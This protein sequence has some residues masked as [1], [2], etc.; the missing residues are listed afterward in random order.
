M[1]K[2]DFDPQ[3]NPKEMVEQVEKNSTQKYGEAD[4]SLT[5]HEDSIM[6]A[7]RALS[8]QV[9]LDSVAP[10]PSKNKEEPAFSSSLPIFRIQST[11]RHRC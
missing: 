8:L 5:I 10:G 2:E 7:E 9:T 3:T 1:K 11:I 6:K 4:D